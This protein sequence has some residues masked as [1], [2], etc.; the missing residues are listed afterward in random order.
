MN[1]LIFFPEGFI[2]TMPVFSYST[3]QPRVWKCI[4]NGQLVSA[5]FWRWRNSHRVQAR[6]FLQ[7][8]CQN[9]AF[10]LILKKLEPEPEKTR[11]DSSAKTNAKHFVQ[12]GITECTRTERGMTDTD[13]DCQSLGKPGTAHV[14]VKQE[15]PVICPH[16]EGNHSTRRY[17]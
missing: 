5:L 9:Q 1:L 13:N 7:Y 14:V 15:S 8:Q 10:S 16:E 4:A 11:K 3:L 2:I 6:Q 17:K 12:Q